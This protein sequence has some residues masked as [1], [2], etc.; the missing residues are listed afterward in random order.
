M[1]RKVLFLC[2]L[3]LLQPLCLV[4]QDNVIDRVEWVV[5][6]K[7]ILRSDIEEAIRFWQGNGRRFEGDPYCVVGE[8]L[9]VQQLFIH[10]AALDSI[11]VDETEIMRKVESQISYVISQIGSKEKM[12]EYFDKNSSEIR[13]MYREQLYNMEMMERMKQKIVGEIKVSPILVRRFYDSL[14]KDSIP[15]IQQQ[16]EVQVITLEPEIDV[17]EIERVKGELREYTERITNKETSFSTLALLYSEDPGSARRGGEL[18][19]MGRGQLQPEFATVAFSLTDPNKVSKIVETEY[20]FHIIQLMEK[21][22]D[23]V[24]VRHIL[25]KPQYSTDNIKKMLL[26]LDSIASDIK[27]EKFTFEEGAEVISHDKETRNNYGMMY[28]KMTASSHFKMDELPVDVARVI[29]G[30]KVG[31]ISQPFTW[32]QD[33][34]KTVCAIVKL[35]SKTD[36][37][38]ATLADDYETLQGLYQA[39]LSDE[40]IREWIK[41]KQQNTYV[42]INRDSHECDFLYPDWKFFEE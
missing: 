30:M 27:E 8:D 4:A 14:P 9:A 25:R 5:G 7:C 32:L 40:R 38:L 22:G 3:S 11:V 12:E 2:I 26:R 20:G 10:Q 15:F 28:N 39:K 36:A 41:E 1:M 29:D 24:K 23:R 19:F 33:N 16:V 18:D 42:R 13:E 21:R 35:K 34:G 17:E 6:D 31:E 37:H